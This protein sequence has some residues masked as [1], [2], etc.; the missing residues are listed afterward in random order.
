M[1][2]RKELSEEFHSET[3]LLAPC[4]SAGSCSGLSCWAGWEVCHGWVTHQ[5]GWCQ[6]AWSPPPQLVVGDQEP[7]CSG[8]ASVWQLT[9]GAVG[10]F[11]PRT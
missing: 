11:Q 1:E 4:C 6:A 3:H 10:V 8:F 9:E 7:H 5:L 2:G